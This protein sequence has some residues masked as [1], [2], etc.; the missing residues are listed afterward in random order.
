MS[1]W[2]KI[3]GVV[4]GIGTTR[5][6]YQQTLG[7]S[8]KFKYDSLVAQR[9]AQ[10]V[11]QDITL[12]KQ[13]GKAER[14][15]IS[16]EAEQMAGEG[17]V[18]YAAGNVQVDTGTPLEY[19]IAVAEEAARGKTRSKEDEAIRVQRLQNE[20]KGLLEESRYLRKAA[21]KTRRSG[22]VGAVGGL[23]QSIGSAMG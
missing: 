14:A 19:D 23:L 9:N 10:L 16:K 21:R 7:Q 8:Q 17:R 12:T 6:G 20:R 18:G 11:E 4:G 22:Q 15:D 13:A 5:A 2:G 1:A 3:L